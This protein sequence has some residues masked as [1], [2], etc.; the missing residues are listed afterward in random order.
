MRKTKSCPSGWRSQTFQFPSTQ[1][2][3]IAT[4]TK[5][6]HRNGKGNLPPS[7][8]KGLFFRQTLDGVMWR[9]YGGMQVTVSGFLAVVI[10]LRNCG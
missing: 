9:T 5:L 8:G 10:K 7:G 1:S 4:V 6:P 3:S 2:L